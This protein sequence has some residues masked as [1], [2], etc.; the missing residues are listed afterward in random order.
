M[1]DH[2]MQLQATSAVSTEGCGVVGTHASLR[3]GG[4]RSG[5]RWKVDQHTCNDRGLDPI[6]QDAKMPCKIKGLQPNP[7]RK[8]EDEELDVTY[9]NLSTFSGGR[10]GCMRLHA[11]HSSVLVHA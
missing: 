3:F 1:G 10:D 11:I 4:V 2:G 7:R 9:H 8:V 5:E 6:C